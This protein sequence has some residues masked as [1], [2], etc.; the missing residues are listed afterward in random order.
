M[1]DAAPVKRNAFE[2]MAA[3]ARKP[4]KQPTIISPKKSTSSSSTTA[5]AAAA[6]TSTSSKDKDTNKEKAP[7]VFTKSLFKE[8]GLG[9]GPRH[10]VDINDQPWVEKQLSSSCSSRWYG[11]DKGSL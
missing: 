1:V 8:S 5:A 10:V 2:M 9:S 6:S 7:V 4:V 11:T 3:A